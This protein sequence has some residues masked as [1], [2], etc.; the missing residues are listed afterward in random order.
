MITGIQKPKPSKRK[1]SLKSEAVHGVVKDFL[2]FLNKGV[3][4]KTWYFSQPYFRLP[5]EQEFHEIV[6]HRRRFEGKSLQEYYN[7]KPDLHDEPIYEFFKRYVRSEVL[8]RNLPRDFYWYDAKVQEPMK[9]SPTT[10]QCLIQEHTC[11]ILC[12]QMYLE[13]PSNC[14]ALTFNRNRPVSDIGH[15]FHTE[16]DNEARESDLAKLFQDRQSY[17]YCFSQSGYLRLLEFK[18]K[19]EKLS[20][21]YN[22]CELDGPAC[23][24]G[25]MIRRVHTIYVDTLSGTF[26]PKLENINVF[27]SILRRTFPFTKF[28]FKKDSSYL[29]TGWMYADHPDY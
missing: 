22:I 11:D 16:P 9:E 26:R 8:H 21:H 4:I 18:D 25:V 15:V 20:K 6:K 5:T 24:A 7:S 29:H 27:E 13:A 3:E 28:E 12:H 1:N 2:K 19:C 14:P 17:M 23:C 10:R